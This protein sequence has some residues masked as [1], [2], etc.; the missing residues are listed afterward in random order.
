MVWEI[1]TEELLKKY[2]SGKRN[3]A[4]AVVVRNKTSGR[5]YIDLE[6]A[7][8]RDINFRGA[9]LSFADLRGADL[10]GADLFG[11]SLIEARLDNAIIRDANLECVTLCGCNLTNADL[12]GT[13]LDYMN[14]T[15][16]IFRGAK[17]T[18]FGHAVLTEAD[19]RGATPALHDMICRGMNFIDKTIMFDGTIEFGP[20]FGEWKS[21][22]K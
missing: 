18:P 14:A 22:S 4:G 12:T 10:S 13:A 20:Y 15:D 17:L 1:T 5:S 16:A 3:F 2:T 8:L 21:I 19:F 6:G 11:A 9:D 7:I